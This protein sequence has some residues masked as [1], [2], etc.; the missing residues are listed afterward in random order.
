MLGFLA[1]ITGEPAL[2]GCALTKASAA[3]VVQGQDIAVKNLDIEASGLL[4]VRGVIRISNKNLEG[5]LDLGLRRNLG[6]IISTATGG[7]LFRQEE[8]GYLCEPVRI[9]GTL[10]NPNN[11]LDAKLKSAAIRGLVRTGAQLIE[12]AA[13]VNGQ[14]SGQDAAG[15]VLNGIRS[16]LAP[17]NP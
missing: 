9:A 14:G 3:F 11:D 12:K 10:E 17:P 8:D 5:N 2:R 7:E 6:T 1:I 4:R 13:G 15:Q 16:L